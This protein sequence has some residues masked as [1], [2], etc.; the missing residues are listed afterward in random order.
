MGRPLQFCRAAGALLL[1]SLPVLAQSYVPM[2]EPGHVEAY[3]ASCWTT[4]IP[5]TLIPNCPIYISTFSYPGTNAHTEAG[6]NP[7]TQPKSKISPSDTGPWYDGLY[8][9][10]GESGYVLFYLKAGQREYSTMDPRRMV[11]LAE[12]VRVEKLDGGLSDSEYY[13]VG[14][15]DIYWV[16]E[17]PQ[18]I[19]IGATFQ[20]GNSNS[21]NHW[22]T[23]YAAYQI[24]YTAIDFLS[25]HP[26]QGKIAVND[27]ALPFG[28]LFDITGDWEPKHWEHGRG[29]A[30]DVRGNTQLYGIPDDQQDEFV[31]LCKLKGAIEAQIEYRGEAQQHIHC[32]WPNP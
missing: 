14:Y 26:E 13:A 7:Y 8:R 9:N 11:G 31:A 1:A 20:H 5:P 18:W 19:H 32:R 12:R 27:M 3:N 24:W 4:D 17:K 2:F 21:Y 28:G 25:N 22:M 6:H 29:T 10:T 15:S 30:V 23:S 16:E